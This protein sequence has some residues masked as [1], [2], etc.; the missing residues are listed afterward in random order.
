MK[1]AVIFPGIG[2]HTDKPLLY[3]AKRLVKSM[4]YEI[5]EVPYG[6]FPEGVKGSQEKMR[7]AFESAVA[8][9]KKLLK[10][11]AFESCDR[12]LFI[13]KSI[14]TAVAAEYAKQHGLKADF[15][16]YTPVE[17]TFLFVEQGGIVF[18]G[19]SDAWVETEIVKREC[20]KKGL[21]LFI[22]E[23][24]NHSLE[25]GDVERD[26]CNLREIMKQTKSYIEQ[27]E[28]ETSES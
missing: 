22:T 1:L 4:G 24:A 20:G 2:Y 28:K 7:E 16:F 14:G 12:L 13:S 19:T 17:E 25:T 15:V 8:Q 5:L 10:D 6:N 9:T 23:G 3:Y 21:P 18:H 27:M 11:T 26:L